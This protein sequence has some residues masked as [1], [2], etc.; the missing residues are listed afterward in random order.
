VPRLIIGIAIG[1]AV[2]AWVGWLVIGS[3]FDAPWY[4]A[5]PMSLLFGLAVVA[6]LVKQTWR[7]Y[8]VAAVCGLAAIGILFAHWAG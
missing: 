1:L 7:G 6:W 3:A 2:L 8:A 4:V 5:I